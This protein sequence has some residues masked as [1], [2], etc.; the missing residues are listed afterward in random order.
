VP[1]EQNAQKPNS[2]F[3]LELTRHNTPSRGAI[4]SVTIWQE[5]LPARFYASPVW[6]ENRLYLTSKA[7]E[8]FVVAA[9]DKY[10]LLAQNTLG[11]PS[12]ATPAVANGKSVLPHGV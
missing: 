4:T 12:F 8:L 5:R 10:Q 7:G 1:P 6:A 9:G 11:E 3:R 2:R